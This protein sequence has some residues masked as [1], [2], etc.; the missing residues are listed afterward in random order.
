LLAKIGDR[1]DEGQPIAKI[2]APGEQSAAEAEKQV[3]SAY[4]FGESAEKKKILLGYIDEEGSHI[5]QDN[6]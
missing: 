2:Y 3:L 5:D 1:G 4:S 6:S